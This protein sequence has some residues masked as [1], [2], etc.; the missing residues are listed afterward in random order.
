MR[1]LSRSGF[2]LLSEDGKVQMQPGWL[3]S[4]AEPCPPL[5]VFQDFRSLPEQSSKA[6]TTCQ[7]VSAVEEWDNQVF[8][9]VLQENADHDHSR[10]CRRSALV[11]G[12]S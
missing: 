1:D 8:S 10:R 12:F 7:A 9:L 2:S 4:K 5:C 6:T 11:W 3:V